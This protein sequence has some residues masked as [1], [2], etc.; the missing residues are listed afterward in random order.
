VLTG[1]ATV[2][3]F[4]GSSFAGAYSHYCCGF[5]K[6]GDRYSASWPHIAIFCPQCGELW[7]RRVYLYEFDYQPYLA[8]PWRV[9]TASCLAHGG[10]QLLPTGDEDAADEQ[11]IKR[12]FNL[13]MQQLE[14]S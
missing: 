2:Q 1:N 14:R 7:G 13:L 3:C 6:S 10:G 9:E 5:D 8:V 4:E 11:L 12:E